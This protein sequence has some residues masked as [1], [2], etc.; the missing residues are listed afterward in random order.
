MFHVLVVVLILLLVMGQIVMAT[1][2]K[3]CLDFVLCIFNCLPYVELDRDN[4][5][6]TQRGCQRKII[7]DYDIKLLN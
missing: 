1:V 2:H 7:Q 3:K 4:L 5:S 6:N